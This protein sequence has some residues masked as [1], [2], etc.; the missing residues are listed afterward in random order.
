VSKD[1]LQKPL[2]IGGIGL[3]NAGNGRDDGGQCSWPLCRNSAEEVAQLGCDLT[4]VL[5]QDND[6][7]SD[8]R[9]SCN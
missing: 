6:P 1:I 8:E 5:M 2:V 3:Q 7:E 9:G 4:Q